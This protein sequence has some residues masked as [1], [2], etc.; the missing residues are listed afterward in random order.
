MD[1]ERVTIPL[2]RAIPAG[3]VAMSSSQNR[4][5]MPLDGRGIKIPPKRGLGLTLM[6]NLVRQIQGT[7]E[8]V[9]LDSGAK[10][11]LCFPVTIQDSLR[12]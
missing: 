5:N 7:V 9:Q 12:S 2:D 6:E 4:S 10:T 8:Y 3:L 11:V 1:V